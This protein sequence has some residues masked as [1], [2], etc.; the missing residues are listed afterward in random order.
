MTLLAYVFG[1]FENSFGGNQICK[2]HFTLTQFFFRVIIDFYLFFSI[3]FLR[4]EEWMK[5]INLKKK[6]IFIPTQNRYY[7]CFYF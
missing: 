1:F 2:T 4:F 7:Y 5:N 3:T 6:T